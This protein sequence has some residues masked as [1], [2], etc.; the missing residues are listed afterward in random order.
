MVSNYS[1]IFKRPFGWLENI[2]LGNVGRNLKQLK[3]QLRKNTWF[4]VLLPSLFL[5]RVLSPNSP[6]LLLVSELPGHRTVSHWHICI[7][8]WSPR[9]HRL[10]SSFLQKLCVS[11]QPP[12]WFCG[13]L[14]MKKEAPG[15]C[16][17]LLAV[18]CCEKSIG[19]GWR[20]R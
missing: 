13:I 1:K 7:N 19:W 15:Y 2:L 6:T 8:M 9:V 11:H 20:R 14:V 10:E 12:Q 5:S 16:T 18:S 4:I 17:S 3:L